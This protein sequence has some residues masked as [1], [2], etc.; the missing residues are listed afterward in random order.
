MQDY[1]SNSLK[2]YFDNDNEIMTHQTVQER[3]Q[4]KDFEFFME[5]GNFLKV[6]DTLEKYQQGA[7]DPATPQGRDFIVFK[8][9]LYQMYEVRHRSVWEHE[10][11]SMQVDRSK[12]LWLQ[13]ASRN[14]QMEMM[15]IDHLDM[16]SDKSR[17]QGKVFKTK[18]L[19]PDRLKGV[20]ALF[21]ASQAFM[22]M[23]ALSL[24]VGS[25]PAM[26]AVV[27]FSIYGMKKLHKHNEVQSIE[28]GDDGKLTIQCLS[29]NVNAH[30]EIYSMNTMHF[31]MPM[32]TL[33]CSINDIHC[34]TSLGN[35]DQGADDCE[36][37]LLTVNRWFLGEQEFQVPLNLLLPADSFKD[38]QMMEQVMAQKDPEAE[39]NDSFNDLMVG[40]FK[41]RV[42]GG[43]L[44][45]F[46]R[47]NVQQTGLADIA[48]EKQV[49][50]QINEQLGGD[51]TVENIKALQE[52]YGQEHLEQLSDSD[53]YNLYKMHY[54][55]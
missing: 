31:N 23:S 47:M 1:T 37:A 51:M 10:E 25:T 20:G 36:A 38:R 19:S 27:G 21:A 42:A 48:G 22:K 18:M 4:L 3:S 2:E 13:E 11:Y 39:L 28:M 24:L 35:D 26:A 43:G 16:M 8:R 49:E 55:Q 45:F 6:V 40:Q 29:L 33:T 17:L 44:N 30:P 5:Q 34:V 52:A 32:A 54:A 12:T 15:K 9:Q 7:V 41:E 14:Y 53:F 50:M 46:A